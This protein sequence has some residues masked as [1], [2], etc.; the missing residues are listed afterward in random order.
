MGD[1]MSH[2]PPVWV[3]LRERDSHDHHIFKVRTIDVADP[4]NGQEYVRTVLD[5]A[6][7]V[8]VVAVTT[9]QSVVLVRQFRFGIWANTL[10]IPGG[11]VDG[12]EAPATAA[13]RELEEETGFRPETVRLLG[14]SHPN[15]AIQGNRLHSYL[16]LGCTRVNSGK[17]D[18]S[19]DLRVELVPRASVKDLV[20][21]GQITH[22]LVLATLLFEAWQGELH[23]SRA[24]RV[25]EVG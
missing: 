11:M 16:A 17:P 23:R 13:A 3:K 19:E 8:N 4:R 7:W 22:S 9:D 24:K 20:L 5:A 25:S 14:V 18:T 10:E 1:D 21:S 12:T 15:P 6:D 2:E